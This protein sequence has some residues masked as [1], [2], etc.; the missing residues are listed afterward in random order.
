MEKK[1]LPS[2][3]FGKESAAS[4]DGGRGPWSS[5]SSFFLEKVS[6]GENFRSIDR[7]A[8]SLLERDR[9][10]GKNIS[11][12]GAWTRYCFFVGRGGD[13]EEFKKEGLG[14]KEG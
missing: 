1:F 9:S 8:G 14:G 3:I 6:R 7:G 10:I 4:W 5:L 13:E 11:A 12:L 2:Y